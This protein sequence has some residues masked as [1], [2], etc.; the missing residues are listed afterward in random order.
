MI[1]RMV[2]EPNWAASALLVI[3]MQN[4]F[5][6]PDGALPVAG[7][8]DVLPRVQQ[9]VT[10]FRRGQRPVVHVV[11]SYAE[12]GSNAEPF[13]RSH[14][15][16]AGPVVAPGSTGAEIVE[17]LVPEG[18]PRLDWDGLLTG[19]IVSLGPTEHVMYKPR[20]GAFYGTLL[21]GHLRHHEVDTVLTVGC[22]FPNCPRTTIYEASERDFTVAFAQ[23]ACSGVYDR[24]LRELASIGTTVLSADQIVIALPD[25]AA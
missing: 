8:L 9:L 4:D 1:R 24:G 20:W 13:R 12:D 22:N 18:S 23:D 17:G 25:V 7:T 10:A 3:D 14:I 21:E 15:R 2:V 5:V 6:R 16:D 19:G 11:R